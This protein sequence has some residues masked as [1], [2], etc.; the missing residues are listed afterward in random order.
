V[1]LPVQSAFLAQKQ[2]SSASRTR[3]CRWMVYSRDT[4]SAM[5]E[6]WAFPEGFWDD[7]LK[8]VVSGGQ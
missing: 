6:R 3:L 4:T 1:Q 7:I 5:A 2:R 8:A